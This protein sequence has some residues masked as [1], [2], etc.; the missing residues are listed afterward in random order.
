MPNSVTL[1]VP[2]ALLQRARAEAALTNRSVDAVLVDWLQRGAP[3]PDPSY[4]IYTPSGLDAA[5]QRL[6]DA[7]AADKLEDPASES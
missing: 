4:V 6:L 5:A 1:A 7:L 2:D 3:P